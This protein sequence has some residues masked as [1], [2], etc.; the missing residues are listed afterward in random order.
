[1]TQDAWRKRSEWPL[2]AAALVFL[3]AY[4]VQVISNTES[5]AVEFL[6]WYVGSFRS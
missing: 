3:A 6:V 4:S 5:P 1:M 2:L